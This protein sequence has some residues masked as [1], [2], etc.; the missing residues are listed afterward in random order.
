MMPPCKCSMVSPNPI[1]Y[2]VHEIG[3]KPQTARKGKKCA[4]GLEDLPERVD[5]EGSCGGYRSA[6]VLGQ[7][8]I[9]VAGRRQGTVSDRFEEDVQR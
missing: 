8:R 7:L 5:D 3:M 6:G 2:T 9:L 4:L 1:L